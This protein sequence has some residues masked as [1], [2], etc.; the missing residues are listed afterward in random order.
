M[1]F[2]GVEVSPRFCNGIEVTQTNSQ[3]TNSHPNPGLQH[4]LPGS[5]PLDI[6]NATPQSRSQ[7]PSDTQYNNENVPQTDLPDDE[8]CGDEELSEKDGKK[9]DKRCRYCFLTYPHCEIQIQKFEALIG[10]WNRKCKRYIGVREFYDDIYDDDMNFVSK[11]IPHFHLLAD[12]G[13]DE[14]KNAPHIRN[15]KAFHIGGSKHGR[16][17]LQ[18]WHPNI[19]SLVSLDKS[20]YYINKLENQVKKFSNKTF[21]FHVSNLQQ[22]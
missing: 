6:Q 13:V 12:L 21:S 5:Q 8:I 4:I 1:N 19:Q 3:V 10:E 14:K 2:S 22:V 11:G 18:I 15:H 9:L 17:T 7:Q 16:E 20:W